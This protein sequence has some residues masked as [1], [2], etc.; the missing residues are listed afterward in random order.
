MER[1]RKQ[2]SIGGTVNDLSEDASQIDSG[3]R[4][5]QGDDSDLITDISPTSTSVTGA[6]RKMDT[7]IKNTG[8]F[9]APLEKRSQTSGL[10]PFAPLESAR[11]KR[12]EVTNYT[13]NNP[14]PS[15]ALSPQIGL[16]IKTDSRLDPIAKNLENM[17]STAT[18]K[19]FTLSGKGSM[20]LKSNSKK[21]ETSELEKPFVNEKERISSAASSGSFGKNFKSIL[22]DS[23]LTDVRNRTDS[24]SYE[25]EMEDRKSV[26]FNLTALP[27]PKVGD[28]RDMFQDLAT[29][30]ESSSNDDDNV[31]WDFVEGGDG[32]EGAVSHVKEIIVTMNKNTGTKPEIIEL[33]LPPN[34]LS[35]SHMSSSGDNSNKEQTTSGNS[36]TALFDKK[37]EPSGRIKPLYEDTDSESMASIK[38]FNRKLGEFSP[39]VSALAQT[40]KTADGTEHELKKAKDDQHN[41][42]RERTENER[43]N[44][45]SKIRKAM[46]NDLANLKDLKAQLTQKNKKDLT[47]FASVGKLRKENESDLHK[48]SEIN[49]QKFEERRAQL[50][51]DHQKLL[52]DLIKEMAEEA[53]DKKIDLES[54]HNVEVEKFK[55]QLKD[56]FDEKRKYLIA[57]HRKAEEQL[58]QNHKVILEE[59][60]RDLKSEEDLIRKDHTNNLA[61]M[62]EKLADELD[63]ERQRMRE[64]GENRLYEKVRCEK[65]LLEDKYRCLKEKYVRLKSDVKISLERRTQRR[66]QQS[67]TTGS[68][69][70]RSNSNKQQS[71][72]NGDV[73]SSSLSATSKNI[74]IGRPPSSLFTQRKSRE[75]IRDKSL[76][77]D[78]SAN[79][80]DKSN[81]KF[82]AAAKYLS[83]I[84][85]QYQDDNTSISQSDTTIS[86]N[87]HRSNRPAQ[88]TLGD[89]GNSDSEALHGMQENNNNVRD[90]HGRQRKKVFTRMKSAS[91]SR[92]NSTNLRGMDT[93]LR[94]CTPV[95]NLRRQLQKLED[96]EDQFPDNSL[97][98]TYHLRYPFNVESSKDHAGSSSELEFFKHR[99]HLERDSVRR[100]KESLRAQRTNFR[101]RQREIKHRHKSA[102]RHT[103]DQMIQ[104]EK[105]LTEMEV[106]LHRTRALLGE[107]VIRLRHLEQSLQRLYENE[108]P[109][110]HQLTADEKF[111]NKDDPTISDL[112]SHSSSG[113]SSTDFASDTHQG[114]EQRKEMFQESSEIIQS[115]EN[116]N[117]EIREIWD[118]LSK[119]Q[120]HGS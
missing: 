27:K 16:T 41:E 26:R 5:L 117:A 119:Q 96:L 15:P 33:K 72:G 6:I 56:E 78:R 68:E 79:L 12:F 73:R 116:L 92:L 31:G 47:F 82:G 54:Q 24:K 7:S 63:L 91:T 110:L 21:N 70:E 49:N 19:G 94:P 98:T 17:S 71:F 28:K 67:I 104:E 51:A 55:Q 106:N 89:N 97:D 39:K 35:D 77:R 95:E 3:I 75:P 29:S 43:A 87:Y 83:H 61:Q 30:D 66:E 52:N 113:F 38:S 36:L 25:S 115:L 109:L 76:D 102:T 90:N 86:N 108:K 58:Q 37:L 50:E 103:V 9:L 101:A 13:T 100:A 59:L 105:E 10:L 40:A 120:S 65:R 62:K 93:Q 22:R 42:F 84:Q 44:E 88:Q 69:T 118:I 46:T 45:E 60:E 74:D 14:L 99:I 34:E 81:K 1:A 2:H 4:S 80:V 23:S 57:E 32:D 112:S 107:K 11:H 111:N 20:F 48:E 18:F 8:R 64:T 85:Q 53:K 114:N